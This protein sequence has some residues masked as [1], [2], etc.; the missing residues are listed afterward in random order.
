[1]GGAEGSECTDERAQALAFDTVLVREWT[2]EPFVFYFDTVSLPAADRED[3]EHILVTV[4]RLSE[5]IE[6]QIG[7]SR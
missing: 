3:A 5:R 7:Y 6:D 1:M 4:E 2:G